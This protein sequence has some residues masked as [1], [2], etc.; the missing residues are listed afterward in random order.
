MG[1]PY[2]ELADYWRRVA[3]LYRGVREGEGDAAIRLARFRREKDILFGEHP[4]SPVPVGSRATFGGLA[5]W[6]YQAELRV[7]GLFTPQRDASAEAVPSSGGGT[8]ELRHIGQV[9]FDIGDEIHR[10]GV[11]WFDDYA[12]G[13]FIPFRDATN[14]SETYGGGRY[15]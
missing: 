6:P 7:V 2:L 4:Q 11:Y 15:L 3:S 14:G 5:N 9:A 10:L 1:D 8:M 12:G 13:I